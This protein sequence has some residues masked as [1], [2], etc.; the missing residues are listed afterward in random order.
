VNGNR[1]GVL[2]LA[3]W[4]FGVFLIYRGARAA[5]EGARSSRW[6]AAQGRI[7]RSAAYWGLAR[8]GIQTMWAYRLDINYQYEAGGRTYEG[9]RVSFSAWDPQH[10]LNLFNGWTAAR[11]PAGTAVSVHFDPADPALS[12]IESGVRISAWMAMLL[13]IILIRLGARFK[14]QA[15]SGEPPSAPARQPTVEEA[16]MLALSG[17]LIAAIKAYRKATGAGL[18]EAKDHLEAFLA[19]TKSK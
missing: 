6:P 18:K 16:K 19:E 17:D 10:S 15:S 14:Y 11:Y 5:Y 7:T 9:H 1:T 4:L 8:R 13:G 3:C 2:F 12:V